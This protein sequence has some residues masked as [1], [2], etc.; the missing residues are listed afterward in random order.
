MPLLIGQPDGFLV[1]AS[2]RADFEDGQSFAVD[3]T[4]FLHRHTGGSLYRGYY[5]LAPGYNIIFELLNPG[6][7]SRLY[8]TWTGPNR[9]V[10]QTDVHSDYFSYWQIG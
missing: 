6:P 1:E 9:E 10:Y 3:G 8:V 4:F 5:N 2:V 7:S